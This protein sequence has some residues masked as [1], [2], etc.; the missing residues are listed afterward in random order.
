MGAPADGKQDITT[1]WTDEDVEDI[2]RI[3]TDQSDLTREDW[4]R[5]RG[6]RMLLRKGIEAYDSGR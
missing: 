5:N 3:C 4:P 2:D 1:R 6:I